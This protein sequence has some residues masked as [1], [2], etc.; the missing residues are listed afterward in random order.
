MAKYGTTSS[1]LHAVA[2]I[3]I[4]CGFAAYKPVLQSRVYR[5]GLCVAMKNRI[6]VSM[7]AE[8]RPEPTEP[9]MQEFRRAVEETCDSLNLN[10]TIQQVRSKL[11]DI[12]QGLE[13]LA[14]LPSVP[15][16]PEA[17]LELFDKH[18]AIMEG[19]RAR[20]KPPLLRADVASQN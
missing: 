1:V 6:A 15:R 12:L 18:S 19:I 4:H 7:A 14:N 20:S 3:D 17:S 10:A 9:S 11:G 2:V 8:L 13:C 5:L 16:S